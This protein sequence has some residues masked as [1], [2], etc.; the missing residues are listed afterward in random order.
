[1]YVKLMLLLQS[2]LKIRSAYESICIPCGV[3]LDV[4]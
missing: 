2:W 1:M 3:S 4:D